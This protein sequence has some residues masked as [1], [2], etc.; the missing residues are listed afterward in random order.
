MKHCHTCKANKDLE[1]FHKDSTRKDGRYPSC[2]LCANAA[3]RSSRTKATEDQKR[4]ARAVIDEWRRNNP[5]ATRR[6]DRRTKLK[7]YGL[8]VDDYESLL[9]EQGSVCGICGK[10]ESALARTGKVQRLAVDHCAESGKVRGLLCT[11]CNRGIGHLQH[12]ADLLRNAI[13]YLEKV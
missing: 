2:R 1:E 9:R 11:N 7:R 3:K 13:E 6:M 4:R 5:E 8:T 10:E 12:D